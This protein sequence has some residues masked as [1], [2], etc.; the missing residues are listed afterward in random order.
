MKRAV[1]LDDSISYFTESTR[2]HKIYGRLWDEGI[3][4][5]VA[6][7]PAQQGNA[8]I[9]VGAAQLSRG[10]PDEFRTKSH[11]FRIADNPKICNYLNVMAQQRLI[12]VCIHGYDGSQD[13][14]AIQDDVLLSQ[15]IEE[16][17]AIMGKAVPDADITSFVVPEIG[18]SETAFNLLVEYDFHVVTHQ[19]A[20]LASKPS[21]SDPDTMT[22]AAYDRHHFRYGDIF[23][24]PSSDPDNALKA[25]LKRFHASDLLIIRQPHWLF[26]DVDGTLRQD[27]FSIWQ[28][29][30]DTILKLQD[31]D[32]ETFMYLWK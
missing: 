23:L 29:F 11:P 27:M 14:F 28:Q 2:L 31:V 4:I 26:Y 20:K 3:P 30:L 16:G 19:N 25:L 32:F 1:F 12:E 8:K 9:Q 10:V 5:A 24:A 7:T 18:C 13:E 15:K 17:K 21:K 22:I 6:V